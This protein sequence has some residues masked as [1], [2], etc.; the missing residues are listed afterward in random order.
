[1]LIALAYANFIKNCNN[2]KFDV[3]FSN[4][5]FGESISNKQ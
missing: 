2:I 1:M 5:Q 3:E 4:T